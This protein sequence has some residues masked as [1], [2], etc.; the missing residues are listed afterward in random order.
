MGVE[1]PLGCVLRSVAVLHTLRTKRSLVLCRLVY[2]YQIILWTE[3]THFSYS[4][5]PLIEHIDYK[6]TLS[7]NSK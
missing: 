3:N 4:S 1:K 7:I 6:G 2:K 5:L